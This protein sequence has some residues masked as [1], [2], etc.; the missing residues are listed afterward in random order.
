MDMPRRN[1][2]E[3]QRREAVVVDVKDRCK[4]NGGTGIRVQIE[5]IRILPARI[6]RVDLHYVLNET[7]WGAQIDERITFRVYQWKAIER[8]NNSSKEVPKT[9]NLLGSNKLFSENE[10]RIWAQLLEKIRN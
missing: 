3:L 5:R 8:P 1:V 7:V 2:K 4:K 6:P 9:D 10:L